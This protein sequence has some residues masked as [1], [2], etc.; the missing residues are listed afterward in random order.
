M[1][2]DFSR[3]VSVCVRKDLPGWQSVNAVAHLS[4]YF[5][6]LLKDDFSTDRW[7]STK[8]AFQMPRNSQFGIVVLEAERQGLSKLVVEAEERGVAWMGFTKEMIDLADDEQIQAALAATD[9][10][11]VEYLGVGVFGEKPAL[12]ALTKRFKLWS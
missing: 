9:A 1:A 12:K 4:A 5:G 6:N 2:Q 10:S 8:D 11:E 3:Q 7:F